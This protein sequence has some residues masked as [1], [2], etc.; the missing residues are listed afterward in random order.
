[1][2]RGDI[3][4][5]QNKTVKIILKNRFVY[6]CKIEEFLDDSIKIRDKFNNLVLISLEDIMLITEFNN[7]GKIQ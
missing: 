1:M 4:C 7:G 3:L 5:Y 6:C 2:K